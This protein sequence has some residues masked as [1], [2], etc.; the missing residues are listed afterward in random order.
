M[1]LISSS[2]L[3]LPGSSGMCH[4]WQCMWPPSPSRGAPLI[5][6]I[7]N[8]DHFGALFVS[9]VSHYATRYV[10]HGG[11]GARARAVTL[12]G[13][14]RRRERRARQAVLLRCHL[15]EV[16]AKDREHAWTA[17]HDKEKRTSRGVPARRVR[18]TARSVRHTPARG[19]HIPTGAHDGARELAWPRG[20]TKEGKRKRRPIHTNIPMSPPAPA[21]ARITYLSRPRAPHVPASAP[22]GRRRSRSARARTRMARSAEQREDATQHDGT[23][24]TK[25]S[26]KDI[27]P[28]RRPSSFSSVVDKRARTCRSRTVRAPRGVGARA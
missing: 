25:G 24:R 17:N 27:L 13:R 9:A 11:R 21:A 4:M 12:T 5:I 28:R 1:M 8:L 2:P 6:I 7:R 20:S 10:I 22:R 3:A 18:R 15:D 19:A 16:Q 26:R 14:Q 23:T